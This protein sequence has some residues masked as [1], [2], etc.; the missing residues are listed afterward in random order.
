M[1][2]DFYRQGC[3]P[4]FKKH[5]NQK[6]M[7]KVAISEAI[8]KEVATGMTKVKLACRQRIAG[9]KVYEF[10]LNIG[11]I[12]SVR[13]A[14]SVKSNQAMVYFI[15]THLQKTTFSREFEHVLNDLHE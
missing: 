13:L 14:F 15:T 6:Q 4:F 11:K 2:V 5:G 8:A 10:R 3:K 7:I 1:Q 9:Q 12:G